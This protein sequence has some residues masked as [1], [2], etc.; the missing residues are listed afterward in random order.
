MVELPSI[1]PSEAEKGN[2]RLFARH[3]QQEM[4]EI[5]QLPI[6]PVSRKHKFVYHKYVLG[7]ISA[8]KAIAEAK[9]VTAEDTLFGDTEDEVFNY[10]PA[11]TCQHY[12]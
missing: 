7:K 6:Y 1:T 10:T 5:L 4:D 9:Q 2:P 12:H 8:E 11:K 3:T